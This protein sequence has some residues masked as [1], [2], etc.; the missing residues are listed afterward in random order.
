[1]IVYQNLQI[2]YFPNL[3]QLIETLIVQVHFHLKYIEEWKKFLDDKNVTGA[4]LIDLSKAFDCI[5]YDLLVVKRHAYG[6]SMD[7]I[8]FIYSYIK[9]RKQGVKIND[10]QSLFK[11]KVC[12]VCFIRSISQI[13][14]R[15]DIVQHIF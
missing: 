1:M 10:T 7:A 13:H 4:V 11:M 2:R 15:S 5:P 12:L 3:F 14:P 6:H 8:T 9:R